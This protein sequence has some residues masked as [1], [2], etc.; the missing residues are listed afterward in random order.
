MKEPGVCSEPL[1]RELY[2]NAILEEGYKEG[3]KG[4]QSGYKEWI[5]RKRRTKA[6]QKAIIAKM[7]EFL[8]IP[9]RHIETNLEGKP[10]RLH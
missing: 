8:Y 4:L 6:E 1:V 5:N 9:N 10:M 7:E 3:K 2:A